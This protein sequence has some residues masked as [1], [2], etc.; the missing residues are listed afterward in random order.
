[1]VHFKKPKIELPIFIFG[2]G[3]SDSLELVRTI[4]RCEDIRMKKWK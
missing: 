3:I 2:T 1:M 4:R